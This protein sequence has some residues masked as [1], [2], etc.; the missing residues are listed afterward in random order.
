VQRVPANCR[1]E[2]FYNAVQPA[3]DMILLGKELPA[4]ALPKAQDA[5]QAVL[6]KPK[7]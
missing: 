5:G 3:W 1:V 7:P 6:D 4:E 2:E